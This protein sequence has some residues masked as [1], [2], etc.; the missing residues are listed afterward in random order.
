MS[1]SASDPTPRAIVLAAGMGTR[2]RS[3]RPKV[4]HAVAGRPLV[5]HVVAALAA[6]G[7]ERPVV[8]IGPDMD[9]VARAVAP[10]PTV[11]QTERK[12]TGHAAL[13]ARAVIGEAAGTV[14]ILVGDAPLITPQT[15]QT[16]LAARTD[17]GVAVLG[18]RPADATGFGRLVTDAAG[19]VLRIVEHKDA[20]D[21][22]HAIGLCNSGILAVDGARLFG[23]LDRLTPNNAQSEYYLTDIVAL[24]RADDCPVT[25]AE[26]SETEVMGIN[27]RADLARVEAMAQDRL[28]RAAMAGG[29][30]LQDPT[31]TYFCWDTKLGQ[32][33]TIGPNVVFGP[34]VEVA[35]DVEIRAFSHIEG[36]KIASGAIIGPFARLR[37]GADVGP[38]AH[39]GNFVEIKNARLDAGAKANHLTYIGDA[40]IG[41]AANIGAGTITCNYDGFTKARTVIG[42]GAFIGSNSALV[43]PV[44]IGA[45]A[46]IGAGSTIAR[47]VAADALAVERADHV[48]KTGWAARF[49]A[50]KARKKD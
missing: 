30:T 41:A 20:T 35:D 40:D 9:N 47:D 3:T 2:M 28:R 29:A 26:A 32:D 34:G 7:V 5:G 37:P 6:A 8:V 36:A 12:G 22:E 4:L 50:A 25:L 27:S 17:A 13:Q 16:L 33:V 45:G 1:L 24:A 49:R 38:T 23:W 11:V 18:F 42:A 15:L 14:L 48:E 44:T 31:T 21:A 46:I 19:Q 39:V 43:A 10:C